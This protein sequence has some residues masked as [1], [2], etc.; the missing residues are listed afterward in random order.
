MVW[1]KKE[2]EEIEDKPSDENMLQNKLGNAM[3]IDL[4]KM[5]VK[6]QAKMRL[7]YNVISIISKTWWNGHANTKFNPPKKKL[8]GKATKLYWVKHFERLQQSL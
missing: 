2:I 8:K 7:W 1:N 6:Q 3:Y 4:L 5:P